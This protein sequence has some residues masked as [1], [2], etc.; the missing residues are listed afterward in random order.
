MTGDYIAMTKTPLI[1]F[2]K[3][4]SQQSL[5]DAVG[6]AQSAISKMVKS[7]RNITVIQHQGGLIELQEEKTIAMQ[8]QA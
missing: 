1:D 8:K 7:E 5:A 3:D 6:L 4:N 2:L